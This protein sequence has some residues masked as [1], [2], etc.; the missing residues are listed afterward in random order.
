[1]VSSKF[2]IRAFQAFSDPNDFLVSSEKTPILNQDLNRSIEV[3]L[4]QK[5][6]TQLVPDTTGFLLCLHSSPHCALSLSVNCSVEWGGAVKCR[7][8][9]LVQPARIIRKESLFLQGGGGWR[10]GVEETHKES[11]SSKCCHLGVHTTQATDYESKEVLLSSL[12]PR[13]V[14]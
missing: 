10:R 13:A 9:W 12:T 11:T 3:L 4:Q 7:M 5:Q 1:M 2:N 6:M 14:L 8:E